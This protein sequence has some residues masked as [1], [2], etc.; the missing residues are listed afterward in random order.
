MT[1]S[2]S[3]LGYVRS[4][5]CSFTSAAIGLFPLGLPWAIH[6]EKRLKMSMRASLECSRDRS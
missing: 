5:T 6:S 3:F 4:Q 2:Y 1:R